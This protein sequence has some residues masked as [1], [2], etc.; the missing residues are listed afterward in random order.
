MSTTPEEEPVR[1]LLP[2]ANDLNQ[3]CY[4]M[5]TAEGGYVSRLADRVEAAQLGMAGDLLEHAK[6][7]LD[8]RKV[9]E[10]QL[11]FLIARMSESMTDLCRIAVSRGER[12]PVTYEAEGDN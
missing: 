10:D 2:W 9:T 11:R 1:R 6:D 5:T 7:L 8:D 4:L 12:I 3:P